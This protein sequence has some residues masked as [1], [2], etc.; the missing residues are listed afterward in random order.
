MRLDVTEF[1]HVISTAAGAEAL[2]TEAGAMVVVS[3]RA[4]VRPILSTPLVPCV[5]AMD[6]SDVDAVPSQILPS[7][8]V[9]ATGDDLD[10]IL[11]TVGANPQASTALAT[12]LRAN[13]RVDVASGLLA[14]SAVYGVLQ[15]GDE[16]ARWRVANAVKARPAET[17]P[18]VHLERDGNVLRV[19]LCRPHVRNALDARM[20][21]ELAEALLVAL[22]DPSLVVELTGAGRAFCA[23]GDL[24]EFG[25]RRD[26]VTAHLVRLTRNL[27]WL[28]HQMRDRVRV[29]V[30]GPCIGSGIELPAFAESVVARP[31][32]TFAL[33]EVSL[34][35]IP[36][37]GGTVSLPRRIGRH[38]TAWMALTGRTLDAQTA[39]D[40]GLIDSVLPPV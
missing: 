38:R 29:V 30:H 36:G 17:R 26:V 21:D 16:F 18:A 23:G 1:A 32:A 24:D 10:A 9:V 33:P 3:G 12:L 27:G 25:S 14:E 34:G 7:V 35:L 28:I 20:R 15:A 6:A 13:E 8:D 4:D 11:S 19:Q 5:I 39:F 31:D 37:A 2:A 40:I 22:A